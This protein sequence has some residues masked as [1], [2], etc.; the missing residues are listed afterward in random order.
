MP[1]PIIHDASSR[2]GS[3]RRAHE[4]W[5]DTLPTV[6]VTRDWNAV[7]ACLEQV[8]RG[9]SLAVL[10]GTPRNA[11][12]LPAPGAAVFGIQVW[13]TA[14]AEVQ[15]DRASV[16]LPVAGDVLLFNYAAGT[17]SRT[18]IPGGRPVSL[19][20][21]RFSESALARHGAQA[22][23]EMLRD[24]C[25]ASLSR[26][27]NGAFVACMPAPPA[28]MA[29]ARTMAACPQ[30]S[31]LA[32][33]LWWQARAL[34]TLSVTAEL[35]NGAAPQAVMGDAHQAALRA[36]RVLLQRF[37]EDWTAERLARML[38]MSEKRL[39]HAFREIV[40]M[41]VSARLRAIRLD[42]A[43]TML[44]DGRRVTDVAADVGYAS[45]SHFS[46]SFRVQF[47]RSP[48]QWRGTD[49]GVPAA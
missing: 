32:R 33:R 17:A 23:C 13:L 8:D 14:G 7:I 24:R 43:A 27:D 46:Q 18:R 6:P 37:S 16:C 49:S 34:E 35:L 41:T 30:N 20:D 9:V 2:Y 25:A 42:A 19:V 21:I 15:V 10:D 47:G 38:H 36:E 45:L 4:W 12:H 39:Q 29:L 5:R 22:L 48:Q 40:G 3:P 11:V 1:Q 31:Q 28:L 26:P 44:A